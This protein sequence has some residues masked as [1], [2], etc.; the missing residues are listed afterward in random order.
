[1]VP[2]SCNFRK[3]LY[4]SLTILGRTVTVHD[5]WYKFKDREMKLLSMGLILNLLKLLVGAMSILAGIL[6]W[7]QVDN[8]LVME[9]HH[10]VLIFGAVTLLDGAHHLY[11][12]IASES[13]KSTEEVGESIE[14]V[15]QSIEIAGR[16]VED[17]EI[18]IK[19]R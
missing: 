15:D 14:G 2:C 11:D 5:N 18:D 8:D 16:S 9:L 12:A 13:N 7:M 17:L 6:Q 19:R 1:M 4:N 3:R 10:L